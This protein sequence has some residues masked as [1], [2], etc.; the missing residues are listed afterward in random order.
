MLPSDNKGPTLREIFD[1]ICTL[2]P[3][4]RIVEMEAF[5]SELLCVMDGPSLSALRADVV[6]LFPESDSLEI[7]DGHLALI[8]ANCAP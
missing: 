1:G 3:E 8:S 4:Q 7:I 6:R 2:P 5:L